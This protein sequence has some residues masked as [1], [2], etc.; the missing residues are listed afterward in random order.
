MTP[1]GEK[2]GRP[3]PW[4]RWEVAAV[5]GICFLGL[6]LRLFHY[7]QAPSLA[8]NFD[9]LTW[10]W[11]G[12]TLITRHMPYA[13]TNFHSY[14]VVEAR[15]GFGTGFRL[16]HPYFDDPPL[17]SIMVGG[18]AWLRGARHLFDVTPA[19]IRPVPILLSTA[20]IAL[21]AAL[22]RRLLGR[23][24]AIV[25]SALLAVAPGAVLFGRQ[26]EAE[27]LIAPIFLLSLLLLHRVHTGEGGRGAIFGI[28][29]CCL[30]APLAKFSGLAVAVVSALL[31]LTWGHWRAALGCIAAAVLSV[32]LFAAYGA[33]FDFNLWL[34][35]IQEQ[36]QRRHGVMSGYTFITSAAGLGRGLRDG[37][38]ALG[39]MG[40]ALSLAR[41][42]SDRSN[43]L[44]LPAFVYAG[45][46]LL[47]TDERIGPIYG[48]YRISIYPLVYLGAGYLLW[49]AWRQLSPGL[50]LAGLALGGATATTVL[51]GGGRQW[52]PGP[53]PLLLAGAAV[54]V[55]V[56][57]ANG[58]WGRR[59][60]RPARLVVA[61]AIAL[62][63]VACVGE[64]LQLGSVYALI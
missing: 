23:G 22:G 58:R 38:W 28:L 35:V 26:V 24:A 52:T 56:I 15:Y 17:F 25:G 32:G 46:I 47:L 9:E 2:R 29:A 4:L 7:A 54:L 34:A 6:A 36:S 44:A 48:W 60:H 49:E 8:D 63:M 21:V 11:S 33:A 12:L 50:V 64:S 62:M 16:V 3:G 14:P 55:P 30:L 40:L 61:T 57:L 53:L 13:W 5:T 51:F 19:L 1:E 43:L 41:A 27:A 18:F 39:W 45:V 42:R 10:S 59:W 20:T 37:W 31:L